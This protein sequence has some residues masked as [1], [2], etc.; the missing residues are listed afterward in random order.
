MKYKT[1]P[2]VVLTDVCGEFVLVS[3][4]KNRELCPYV[5]TVNET[6]AFLWNRLID[7]ADLS[8]L[9]DAV[10]DEYEIDDAA[11]AEQAVRAF[12]QQMHE[13]NYLVTA[14][15]GGEDEK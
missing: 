6:S 3:A 15:Q 10:R 13:L 8:E 9:M 5:T 14:D 7:G 1:R 12:L 4:K 2:G 11:A